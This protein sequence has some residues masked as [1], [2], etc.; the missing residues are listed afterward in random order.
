MSFLNYSP[1]SIYLINSA[2]VGEAL[3][4]GH[5]VVLRMGDL[6]R[7]DLP[8]LIAVF[9][10]RSIRREEAHLRGASDRLGPP[11]LGPLVALFDLEHHLSPYLILRV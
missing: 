9:F 11:L 8:Y 2:H 6:V 4:A 10:D 7:M 1:S 5:R 3:D